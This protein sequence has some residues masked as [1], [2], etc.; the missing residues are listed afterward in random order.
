[1]LS[2][3]RILF[4]PGRL[5]RSL[6]RGGAARPRCG[7]PRRGHDERRDRADAR[8][9]G[10]HRRLPQREAESAARPLISLFP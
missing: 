7:T 5:E 4:A 10:A 1:M 2:D 3:E 6:E 9:A 8:R